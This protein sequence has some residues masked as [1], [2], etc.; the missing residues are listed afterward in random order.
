MA[1]KRRLKTGKKDSYVF[2]FPEFNPEAYMRHEMRNAK[3]YFGA[4]GYALLMVLISYVI[5]VYGQNVSAGIVIGLLAIAG[6][7]FIPN[8]M[9]L[10]LTEFTWKNWAGCGAIYFFTWLSV[11]VLVSNPPISDLAPPVIEN[12]EFHIKM[13]G[14][15]WN[16]TTELGW[17][18]NTIRIS[19]TI[20]AIKVTVRIVDN[21][22]VDKN[23]VKISVYDHT[24]GTVVAENIRMRNREGAIYESD[25]LPI[26]KFQSGRVYIFKIYVRDVAG[27]E[28]YVH[29]DVK[30][31]S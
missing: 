10:D 2:E 14:D 13:P 21:T 22:A 4:A 31:I 28:T 8:F 23:S 25:E 29:Y 26:F 20:E 30:M 7:K 27:H 1:K 17:K 24:N 19:P 9:R 11:W 15:K 6:I 18:D 3:A 16:T 12:V 5:A